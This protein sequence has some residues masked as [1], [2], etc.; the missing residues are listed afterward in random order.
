[1]TDDGDCGPIG[2][3][4][5]VRGNRSTREKSATMPF[6]PPKIPHDLTRARIWFTE[7][8]KEMSKARCAPKRLPIQVLFFLFGL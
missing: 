8:K 1:M 7:V 6:C 3:M 4:K 2:G 5:I